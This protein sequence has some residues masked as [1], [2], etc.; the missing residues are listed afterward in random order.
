[1]RNYAIADRSNDYVIRFDTHAKTVGAVL[2]Y[3]GMGYED[4]VNSLRK[5]HD[6]P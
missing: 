6:D 4:M 2:I 5:A 1:M 3:T